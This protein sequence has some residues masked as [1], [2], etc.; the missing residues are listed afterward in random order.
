MKTVPGIYH[1]INKVN[2]KRY[3]GSTV[4]LSQR[5]NQHFYKLE[6]NVHTNRYLQAAY[7][8]YGEDSFEFRVIEYVSIDNLTKAEQYWVD[9]Y[10]TSG[11][12]YNLRK[13][14]TNN[15]GVKKTE[16][17]K[18]KIGDFHRGKKLS[19]KQLEQM[20][21]AFTGKKHKQETK[22]LLSQQKTGQLNPMYNKCGK[23]N[24]NSKPVYQVD[25]DSNQI[26]RQWDC[27]SEASRELKISHSRICAC[28]RNRR[29]VKSAGGY[30][31]QYA[32]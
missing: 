19:E 18:K 2:D 15:A 24:H 27:A 4:N 9:Y 1:I 16:E 25:I 30:K 10:Q 21:V 6:R 31:W 29:Y 8:K 12:L 3:I 11:L 7:N 28:A 23:E 13:D 26:I 14:V 20:R 17:Q 5:K 32:D 22:D